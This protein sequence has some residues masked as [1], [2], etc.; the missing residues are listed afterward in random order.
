MEG[1]LRGTLAASF[2]ALC[3][4]S[5]LVVV[6]HILKGISPF[7][8][9]TLTFAGASS[10]IWLEV[11]LT[12]WG[13]KVRAVRERFWHLL[14]IGAVGSTIQVSTL[15][16]LKFSSPINAAIVTRADI[17]IALLLGLAFLGERPRGLDIPGAFLMI[18]GA[19][20]AIGLGEVGFRL[21]AGDICFLVAALGLAVN[22]LLIKVS[23]RWVDRFVVAAFNTGMMCLSNVALMLLFGQGGQF[24]ALLRNLAAPLP[25]VFFALSITSYYIS[26]A[27]LPIWLA[28]A[29]TLLQ[30]PL[31]ALLAALLL[32]EPFLARQAQGMGLLLAGGAMVAAGSKIGQQGPKG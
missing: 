5:Y 28:R 8:L 26:L 2:S 7:V 15:L 29:F 6:K 24:P 23:F 30:P 16:G 13:E 10:L 22:A 12:G 27:N 9:G 11:A 4:A 1:R 19:M 21:G 18:A 25:A 20:R 32:G 14:A 3:Y 17:G 31:A